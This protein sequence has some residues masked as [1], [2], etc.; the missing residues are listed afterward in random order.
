MAVGRRP[1]IYVRRPPGSQDLTK[2]LGVSVLEWG[3]ISRMKGRGGHSRRA[4]A[5][6][7]VRSQ[8]P[9]QELR[10]RA[11]PCIAGLLLLRNTL[12]ACCAPPWVRSP[13]Q[14]W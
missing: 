13:P 2:E 1:A 12:H 14:V 11:Y 7:R 4:D 9:G 5:G 8:L 3:Q 10:L 6:E